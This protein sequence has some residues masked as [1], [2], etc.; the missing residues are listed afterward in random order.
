EVRQAGRLIHLTDFMVEGASKGVKVVM[1]Y[2]DDKGLDEEYGKN[3]SGELTGM[4]HTVVITKVNQEETA[5]HASKK[6]GEVEQYEK[7]VSV[8]Q[9]P[10]GG[11]TTTAWELVKR[12]AVLASEFMRLPL[13]SREKGIGVTAFY[14][15]PVGAYR[16][17]MTPEFIDSLY[18]EPD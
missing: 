9:G 15:T 13:P 4:C 14:V 3:L 2:Q 8:S 5:E 17:T 1:C 6:L 16:H 11:S 18:W 12:P 7:K 10:Q